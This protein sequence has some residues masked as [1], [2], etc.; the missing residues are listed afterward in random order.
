[1][2]EPDGNA[3]IAAAVD[4]FS[5]WEKYRRVIAPIILGVAWL[6]AWEAWVRLGEVPEYK[7]PA[8]SAIIA[9]LRAEWPTLAAAWLVTVKTTLVALAAAVVI[10]VALAVLFASSRIVEI[11]LFPYAVMLQVTPLVAVA[12]FIVIWIGW[13]R[14]WLTQLVCAWI[15]AF[16][17]VVSNTAMGLQSA[18]RGSR[19]LFALYGATGWQRLRLLLAPSALPYFLAGLKVSANLALVG[20]VVAEFVIGTQVDNPGLASMIFESQLRSDTATMFAALSLVSLTG[21]AT[22]FIMQGLSFLLLRR[23]HE[24]AVD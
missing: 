3:E 16:F 18:D 22:F 11:S 21:I 12:P 5:P 10:G 1:M 2:P 7:L 19:D 9:T 17:P 24:S 8:P 13:E 14:V 6:A 20:A 4:S 15:V 23:W